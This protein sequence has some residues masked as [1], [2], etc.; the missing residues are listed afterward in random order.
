MDVGGGILNGVYFSLSDNKSK[1]IENIPM[2]QAIEDAKSQAENAA[3]TLTLK[4]I[5]VKSINL[6]ELSRYPPIRAPQSFISQNTLEETTAFSDISRT[7]RPVI[8]GG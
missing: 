5:A 2:K 6:N 7:T 3:S 1:T 8:P 4:V